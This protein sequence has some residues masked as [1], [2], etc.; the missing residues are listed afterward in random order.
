MHER[1]DGMFSALVEE[2]D[3]KREEKEEITDDIHGR[4][5]SWRQAAVDQIHP[6]MAFI[7]GAGPQMDDVAVFGDFVHCKGQ[8]PQGIVYVSIGIVETI[9]TYCIIRVH[10]NVTRQGGTDGRE[11][12]TEGHDDRSGLKWRERET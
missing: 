6:D 3:K 7:I 8:C 4:L 12:E 2:D 9:D 5:P 1:P 11:E 10:I